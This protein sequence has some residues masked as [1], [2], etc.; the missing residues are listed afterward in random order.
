MRIFY[1]KAPFDTKSIITFFL[2]HP[3]KELEEIEPKEKENETDTEQKE[4]NE[5]TDCLGKIPMGVEDSKTQDKCVT[6]DLKKL[7]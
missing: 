2:G 3:L 7:Y 1:R 6:V 4:K 5:N